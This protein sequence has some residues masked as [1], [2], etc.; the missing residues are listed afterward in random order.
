MDG[1][2]LFLMVS[3]L[4]CQGLPLDSQ[5]MKCV[6]T[7][8]DQL[9]VSAAKPTSNGRC[10]FNQQFVFPFRP[11][12]ELKVVVMD[13]DSNTLELHPQDYAIDVVFSDKPRVNVPLAH[14][15]D[16]ATVAE[17]TGAGG[18]KEHA[19]CGRIHVALIVFNTAILKSIIAQIGSDGRQELSAGAHQA[20]GLH[21]RYGARKKVDSDM[22]LQAWNILAQRKKKREKN[23]DQQSKR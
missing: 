20:P 3:L 8:A 13:G 21:I 7:M 4:E 12:S 9:K 16:L 1:S 11:N 19:P 5:S 2:S 6:V 10:F 15:F 17:I 22:L 18:A 23:P 14:W